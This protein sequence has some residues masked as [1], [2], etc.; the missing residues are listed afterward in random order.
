MLEGVVT[1][2]VVILKPG[3]QLPEGARV[4]VELAD[5]DE[6]MPP[7]ATYDREQELAILR[8]SLRDVE[9]GKGMPFGKFMRE[10]A[11]EYKLEP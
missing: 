4:F 3:V 6:P 8:E 2:G 1:N 5:V 7:A 9:A 11:E 10:L